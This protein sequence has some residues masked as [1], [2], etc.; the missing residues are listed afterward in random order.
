MSINSYLDFLSVSS[1]LWAGISS[2][3]RSILEMLFER[4][5]NTCRVQDLITMSHIASQATLHKELKELVAKGY[6]SL[7][8]SPSDGRVKL[9]TLTKKSNQLLDHLSKVLSKCSKSS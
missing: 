9:V 1:K 6:V 5:A 7:K 8:I 2:H 3:G 4:G